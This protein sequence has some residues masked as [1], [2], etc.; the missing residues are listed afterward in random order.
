MMIDL[1]NREYLRIAAYWKD[2][3]V[4]FVMKNGLAYMVSTKIGK[5]FRGIA[6]AFSSLSHTK[7]APTVDDVTTIP[8]EELEGA[9]YNLQHEKIMNCNY[10]KDR[11][12]VTERWLKW[13]RKY[14]AVI[15]DLALYYAEKQAHCSSPVEDIR[16][17]FE[18]RDYVEAA[19]WWP[20]SYVCFVMKN[21]LA[22]CVGLESKEIYID[23]HPY[24][25]FN[26]YGD[27]FIEADKIPQA[28]LAQATQILRT[29]PLPEMSE[30]DIKGCQ[31]WLQLQKNG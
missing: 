5:N 8:Q 20:D 12:E 25:H 7:M 14:Q 2:W 6:V 16:I 27:F 21:G 4:C 19:G 31:Y 26:D 24:A 18:N 29:A 17:E 22:Y 15:D 3:A 11:P 30:E 1:E 9:L 28:E 23:V 10:M 13:T